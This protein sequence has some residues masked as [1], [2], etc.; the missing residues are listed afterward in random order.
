M[1]HRA[2]GRL[3]WYLEELSKKELQQF[4]HQLPKEALGEGFSEASSAQPGK[5]RSREVATHLVTQCG[6]QRAWD[7]ALRTWQ[8]MGLSSLCFRAQADVALMSDPS[9]PFGFASSPRL[10]SPSGPTSTEVLRLWD[11]DLV[12]PLPV[13]RRESMTLADSYEHRADN[14]QAGLHPGNP[15]SMVFTWSPAHNSPRQASPNAP[16]STAVLEACGS[17]PQFSTEAGQQRNA[18][19]EWPWGEISGSCYTGNPESDQNRRTE[20][21]RGQNAQSWKSEDS[22]QKFTQL[23]LLHTPHPRGREPWG[24]ASWQD[25]VLQEQGQLIEVQDLFG[26]DLDTQD[27]PHTVILQGAAGTGKSTLARQVRRAWEQGQLFKDRFRHVFY[28]SCRELAQSRTLSLAELLT[29]DWAAPLA[30]VGQ[31]LSRPE[32]LLFIL[33]G[34]D[35]P[36]WVFGEQTSE[37]YLHWSQQQP[38]PTLLGSLLSKAILPGVSLLITARTRALGELLP[39]SEQP[40]WVE[41]LGFSRAARKDYFYN[42]FPD[43]SQ[44][45]HA[46]S[47]V[48]SNRALLSMCQVPW[49]SW[50]LC[51][52]LQLQMEQGKELSLSCQTTTA[53]C[54]HYLSLALPAQPLGAQLRAL[55]SLAAEGTWQGKTLFR[56]GDLRRH[57]LDGSFIPIFLKTRLLRR[58]QTFLSY[59]FSH[60]CF[61]EF[62]AAIACAFEEKVEGSQGAESTQSVETLPDLYGRHALFGAPTTRFL[63]GLLSERGA[64][65]L[66]DAFH[67]HLAQEAK[68]EL[69]RWVEAQVQDQD[70]PAPTC[71]LE[72]LGCLYEIQDEA[73]LTRALA[74]VHGARLCVRT[75]PELLVFAFCLSFCYN[76]RSL[77]VSQGSQH[78]QALRPPG[79]VLFRW[80]PVTDA[81]WQD[82][83]CMLGVTRS[84]QELDL[85]GNPLNPSAVQSLCEALRQP[86]CHL[87]T[88][89][90]VSCGLTSSC[91][92]DLA[93]VLSASPSLMELDLQQNDLG[94]LGV[95]LLCEGLRHP[96][97]Q[98]KLLWLDQAHFS[99]EVSESLRALEEEKPQLLCRTRRKQSVTA[100]NE[101]PDGGEMSNPTPSLKRQRSETGSN[102]RDLGETR[103]QNRNLTTTLPVPEA[104]SSQAAE[105]KPSCQ[106]SPV[107]WQELHVEPLRTDDDFWGPTGPVATEVI[108]KEKSLYR[109]HF[110]AAGSYHW[111]NTGVHF[112]VKEAVTVEIGFCSWGQYLDGIA[113]RHNWKIAGPL[114]D[115]K[116]EPGVVAAVYLPHFVAFQK[117]RVDTSMFQVAHFKKEGMLLEKPASVE[118]SYV[119]LENPSFSA[120]G[121]LLRVI[122]TAL[123]FIPIISTV[124][125]YHH[126][127]PE[128]VT[129]H[130]YLIPSDC[131]IRKAI[132]DEE[133]KFQFVQLHKPPPLTPLYIGS[134]YTVSSSKNLE[135]NPEELELC[136]RTPGE[137]QL[138][139]EFY[140]GHLGSGIRLE[141]RDKKDGIVVWRALL[142]TGDLRPAASLDLP[143]QAALPPIPDIT[144]PLHFVDRYRE[145]LIARVTSVDPVLDKLHGHMLSEEQYESVRAEATKQDKMRKL[146]SFSRSWNSACKDRLYQALKKTH[147]YLVVD[148]WEEW[149]TT[150]HQGTP[151]NLGI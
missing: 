18:E 81:C 90:L 77:R 40:R 97:C 101:D 76:V 39:S 49:V 143:E 4:C 30:P 20:R 93:S 149:G 71:S 125:L 11:P 105:G 135:I 13:K 16:T 37:L 84:L 121:V 9:S 87:E 111:P 133:K 31:I 23:L 80:L 68:G 140:I 35:E 132:D 146:F 82:L 103:K 2:H 124:L 100:P 7:L 112:V 102:C 38:V 92:Q 59:S 148:L 24:K 50:L 88:L 69:L 17:P 27:A 137:S 48:E 46:F 127:H 5:I 61:Q 10:G 52:C 70:S 129:V 94:T 139:S 33:D 15:P 8:K 116:A 75:D 42:Y 55:C 144:D 36:K 150:V 126:H 67:C 85:S 14:Q 29:Q 141:I 21:P 19:T 106:P 86:R 79:V 113:S 83:F 108:D 72:V 41:V 44:A 109:V 99:D 114:L 43:E 91:C 110:P 26:P 74:H 138:F 54:L 128:E 1:A 131:S 53:L 78:G 120:M 58:H 45:A 57:G 22:H 134:R 147:P 25:G 51:T 3:A 122:H 142:K 123:R 118:A 28:L 56:L 47:L 65:E 136:Y 95:N 96:S 64:R 98:L 107:P 12:T 63:F 62:L 66:E 117:G 104:S 119:V 32:Q 89:R 60:L 73:F 130:L 151:D 6:E 115:I 145:Q 34:L